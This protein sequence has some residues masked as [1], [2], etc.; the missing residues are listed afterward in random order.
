MCRPRARRV[1]F[2]RV[3]LVFLTALGASLSAF[4]GSSG[5]GAAVSAASTLPPGFYEETVATATAYQTTAFVLVP[6][7]RI[8]IAEKPGVVR[9]YKDGALLPT[10]L[11]DIRNRVNQYSDRGLLGLALDPDFATGSPYLYLIYTYEQVQDAD[12]ANDNARKTAHISRF[13]V[14]GDTAEPASEQVLVGKV[15]PQSGSC[16]DVPGADCLPSDGYSHSVGT[17]KFATDK[18]LF[19]TIGDSGDYN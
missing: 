6:D 13:T 18:S 19:A 12:P 14:S 10:P 3:F 5:G 9:V 16:N 1:R 17:L 4:N 7:G 15:T 8:L 2:L 11:L